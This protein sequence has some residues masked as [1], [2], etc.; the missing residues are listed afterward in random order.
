MPLDTYEYPIIEDPQIT[1]IVLFKSKDAIRHVRMSYNCGYRYPIIE[2]LSLLILFVLKARMPLNAYGFY[3]IEGPLM[4][5]D[6][7]EYP[8]V[9]VPL[10]TD[11]SNM[12]SKFKNAIH[13]PKKHLIL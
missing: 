6:T 10:I 9:E 8:I 11:N 4:A 12:L 1:D 2:V 5:L 7:Y 13:I 3:I